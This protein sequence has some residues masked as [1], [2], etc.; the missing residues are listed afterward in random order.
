MPVRAIDPYLPHFLL[1]KIA[2]QSISSR[3]DAIALST[4][5]KRFLAV[6]RP[7]IWNQVSFSPDRPPSSFVTL[8][9]HADI[10]ES[11]F[12]IEVSG[13]LP[14]EEYDPLVHI[15]DCVRDEHA[16]SLIILHLSDMDLSEIP[17][18]VLMG[19]VTGVG[20]V[21]LF[22]CSCSSMTISK[23]VTCAGE[24]HNF[25]LHAAKFGTST[26]HEIAPPPS[27]IRCTFLPSTPAD[28]SLALPW[29]PYVLFRAPIM[30]LTI[31]VFSERAL[32]CLTHF[33]HTLRYLSVAVNSKR[34]HIFCTMD[35]SLIVNSQPSCSLSNNLTV[36]LQLFNDYQGGLRTLRLPLPGAQYRRVGRRCP[37][38]A[39]PF[40]TRLC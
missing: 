23:L 35:H 40:H 37:L 24:M 9:T 15:L 19:M 10:C 5:N 20:E 3:A 12:E 18:A 33:Q 32:R 25:V 29:L 38:P 11:T 27:L 17:I 13:Q 4:V 21:H 36:W 8:Y 26:L 6:A 34:P 28:E 16:H 2:T 39:Y 14:D 31:C 1:D 30:H 7:Y 22:N